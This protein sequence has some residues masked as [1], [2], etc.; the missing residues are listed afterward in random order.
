[1]NNNYIE[2]AEWDSTFFNLKIG[3]FDFNQNHTNSYQEL[4]QLIDND[5]NFDLIYIWSDPYNLETNNL[6]ESIGG[7]L[8]DQKVTLEL[9]LNNYIPNNELNIKSI[10]NFSLTDKIKSL[11][12]QSGEYSRFK[13]D[14]KLGFNNFIK[15]YTTWIEKSIN[16]EIAIESLGYFEENEILGLITLGTKNNKGDIGLLAVD[17]S[18]RG[19]S[20]GKQL[21]NQ[22]FIFFQSNNIKNIQVVTQNNNKN[23][24]EFYKKNNFKVVNIVNIY[25]LWK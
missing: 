19:K 23:A 16:Q 8:Y 20:I 24:L 14:Q 18:H 10:S 5:Y 4:I 3:K 13:L 15:L 11:A 12:Y 21:L 2:K 1:M 22:A 17:E 6:I 9:T 25:H 7:K